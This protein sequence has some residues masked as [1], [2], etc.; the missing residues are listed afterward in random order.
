M[1]NTK[2]NQG[3]PTFKIKFKDGQTQEVSEKTYMNFIY[4]EYNRKK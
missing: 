4:K 1:Y 2:N 3:V